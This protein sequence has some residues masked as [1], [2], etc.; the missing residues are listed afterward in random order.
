MHS[1]EHQLCLGWGARMCM[2]Q[3]APAGANTAFFERRRRLVWTGGVSARCAPFG[4]LE[5]CPKGGRGHMRPRMGPTWGPKTK[6]HENGFYRISASNGVRKWSSAPLLIIKIAKYFRPKVFR[7]KPPDRRAPFPA[8][9]PPRGPRTVGVSRERGSHDPSPPWGNFP[10]AWTTSPDGHLM[11]SVQATGPPE[12][13][14][15]GWQHS[16]CR[17]MVSK[18]QGSIAVL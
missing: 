13:P 17:I 8:P 1:H 5:N 9:P 3:T 7:I 16:P 12:S 2:V 6:K 11:F 10:P 14:T 4:G 15:V 18:A